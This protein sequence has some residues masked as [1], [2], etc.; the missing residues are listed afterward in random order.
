VDLVSSVCF[1]K[2]AASSGVVAAFSFLEALS[3]SIFLPVYVFQF[4]PRRIHG[5]LSLPFCRFPLGF[6]AVFA[7]E[8]FVVAIIL[9]FI[10]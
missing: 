10:V 8:V 7:A 3:I 9:C 2:A 5:I 1:S 6:S 4:T